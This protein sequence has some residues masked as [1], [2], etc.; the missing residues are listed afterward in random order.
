M[1]LKTTVTNIYFTTTFKKI[2]L[3]DYINLNKTLLILGM[4]VFNSDKRF[5]LT[6]HCVAAGMECCT[7]MRTNICINIHPSIF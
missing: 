6:T 3:C 2:A 7:L 1:N 4:A 5:R